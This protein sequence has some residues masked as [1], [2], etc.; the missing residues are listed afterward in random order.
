MSTSPQASDPTIWQVALTSLT[1]LA[2]IVMYQIRRLTN[3]VDL[4]EKNNVTREE[5]NG[6]LN[7]FKDEH[8]TAVQN[9]RQD[10]RDLSNEITRRHDAM[11][12]RHDET[13]KLLLAQHHKQA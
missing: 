12:A 8:G 6:A 3:R 1:G 11:I 5:F 7:R 2:A 4:Q 13:L 9:L 10:M